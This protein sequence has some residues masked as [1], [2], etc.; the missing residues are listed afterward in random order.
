MDR[1]TTRK[2]KIM[3]T[4]SIL[5]VLFLLPAACSRTST[6]TSGGRQDVAHAAPQLSSRD[7][8]RYQYFFLEAVRMQEQGKLDAAHDLL[9]HAL[10]INPNAPEAHYLM[11]MYLSDLGLDS[12]IRH[13]LELAAELAPDNSTYQERLA[14]YF[15]STKHYDEALA[16]YE[17]LARKPPTTMTWRF[18]CSS[19]RTSATTT[20]CS[21]SSQ[22]RR[23]AGGYKRRTDAHQDEGHE[24]RGDQSSTPRPAVAGR[25]HPNDLSLAN[26]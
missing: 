23:A 13:H 3:L 22:P 10:S 1:Q 2:I 12:A 18:S 21:M 20:G 6:L 16:V 14:Q 15:I 25:Q 7:S 24:Q 4:G 8:M 11:A 19:T 17:E 5:A 9:S 26:V